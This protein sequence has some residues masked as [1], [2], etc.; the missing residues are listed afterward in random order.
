MGSAATE[1]V[2]SLEVLNEAV[3]RIET[4][5]IEQLAG[6]G[7]RIIQVPGKAVLTRK[8]G[9]GKRRFR[10]VACG[11]YVPAEAH[12]SMSLYASGV[13]GLT[14]RTAL[15][16]AAYV[17][18]SALTSDIRTAFLHAPLTDD[19]DPEEIIIVK[20]PSLLVEM[21][22]LEPNHRW[23]VLKALYGLRQAPLAWARFRDKSLRALTFQYGGVWYALRQGIS[24][25]SLW[26]IVKSEVGRG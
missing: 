20:P 24:D 25:D 6:G 12:D 2:H 14:V 17:G 26:F 22:I 23:R 15:A 21:K 13:E 18:W 1:E 19:L 5:D 9:I 10:C 3:L 16:Y 11:N 7:K 8:A 4:A